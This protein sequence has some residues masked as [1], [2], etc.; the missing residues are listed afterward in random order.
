M[1]DS[2]KGGLLN[3]TNSTTTI[4]IKDLAKKIRVFAEKLT[5]PSTAFNLAGVLNWSKKGDL[6]LFT[7][8][9]VKAELDVELLATAFNMGKADFNLR[10]I[11]LDTLGGKVQASDNKYYTPIAF[12]A[13]RDILQ[14][15]DTVN[16]TSTFYNAERLTTNY[17]AHKHGIMAGCQFAQG[18]VLVKNDGS[19]SA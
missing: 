9:E 18:V 6:V 16:T 15:Y 2:A 8:P 3:T 12:L 13:D 11:T 1:S 14:I 10:V 17:F 5:F 19:A 7:T 4:D